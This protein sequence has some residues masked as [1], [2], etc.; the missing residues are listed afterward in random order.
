MFLFHPPKPLVS[1]ILLLKRALVLHILRWLRVPRPSSVSDDLHPVLRTRAL[2][3]LYRDTIPVHS[4]SFV[5]TV[6]QPPS[7]RVSP[8]HLSLKRITRRSILNTVESG[9]QR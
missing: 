7:A 1:L 2:D 9:K 4:P 3:D 6:K 5:A 8:Y